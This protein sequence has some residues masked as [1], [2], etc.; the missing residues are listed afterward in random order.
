MYPMGLYSRYRDAAEAS[1]LRKLV[2]G[3][4]RSATR[5]QHNVLHPCIAAQAMSLAHNCSVQNYLAQAAATGARARCMA[6]LMRHLCSA[7][8]GAPPA[9][10]AQSGAAP[11]SFALSPRPVSALC[12]SAAG[13]CTPLAGLGTPR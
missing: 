10:C 6:Y 5:P 3:H 8:A 13:T 11:V 12:R 4:S 7:A 2:P 9:R 1:E